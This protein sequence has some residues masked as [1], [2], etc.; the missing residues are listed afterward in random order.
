MKNKIILKTEDV[1]TGVPFTLGSDITFIVIQSRGRLYVL[2]KSDNRIEP[3]KRFKRWYPTCLVSKT[4]L[5]KEN[6]S[7]Y[8]LESYWYNTKTKQL[9]YK[10]YS[11][12]SNEYC[13]VGDLCKKHY[14]DFDEMIYLGRDYKLALEAMNG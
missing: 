13:C 14:F 1:P 2:D 5:K 8:F 12:W 4:D 10:T 9:F 11:S 7:S 6:V 3:I